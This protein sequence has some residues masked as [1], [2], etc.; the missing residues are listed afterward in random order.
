VEFFRHFLYT[1]ELKNDVDIEECVHLFEL[2]VILNV[3]QLMNRVLKILPKVINTK[4]FE[5]GFKLAFESD[6]NEG[7]KMHAL[8]TCFYNYHI[9]YKS[10]LSI[11]DTPL[12]K[13][14]NSIKKKDD[15]HIDDDNFNVIIQSVKKKLWNTKE[16]HD[17]ELVCTDDVH[18]RC[19][20]AIL[21]ISPLF[22]KFDS[23]MNHDNYVV[24]YES[25]PLLLFLELMYTGQVSIQNTPCDV[26]FDLYHL[27]NQSNFN[28]LSDDVLDMLERMMDKNNYNKMMDFYLSGQLD[29]S[30]FLS[31][32][33]QYMKSGSPNSLCEIYLSC[34]TKNPSM[35][36]QVRQS[37]VVAI[38]QENS[39]SWLAALDEHEIDDQTLWEKLGTIMNPDTFHLWNIFQTKLSKANSRIDRLEKTLTELLA[40]LEKK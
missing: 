11:H 25:K 35:L 6:H 24:D 40:K 12:R 28:D 9:D 33:Q 27:L 39:S 19:H 5:Q 4:N 34:Q 30:T 3:P 8:L 20:K 22:A 1:N 36:K 14:L 10:N 37:I 29:D 32:V 16:Y 7:D 18:I 21:S 23:N 13:T 2:S 38:N 15:I 31:K 17:I 26:L